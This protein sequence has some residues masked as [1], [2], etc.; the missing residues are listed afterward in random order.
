VKRRHGQHHGVAKQQAAVTAKRHDSRRR[1][2]I[3]GLV[4]AL[5]PRRV[6][7]YGGRGISMA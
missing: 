5:M 6:T 3:I 2:N 7:A 1:S 4:A